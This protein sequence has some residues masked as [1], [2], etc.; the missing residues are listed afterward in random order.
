MYV[1]Y[2]TYY[3]FIKMY[4]QEPERDGPLKFT[5]LSL[6]ILQNKK[7]FTILQK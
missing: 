1:F 4:K 6:D 5:K 7:L 2:D 3:I